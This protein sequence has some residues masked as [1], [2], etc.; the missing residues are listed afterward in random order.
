MGHGL[1][2]R[3]MATV[4][5]TVFMDAVIATA[6]ARIQLKPLSFIQKSFIWIKVTCVQHMVYSLNPKKAPLGHKSFSFCEQIL[7]KGLVDAS[8]NWLQSTAKII[9]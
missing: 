2:C 6:A 1:V 7:H 9:F 5:E 4:M 8:C 3:V